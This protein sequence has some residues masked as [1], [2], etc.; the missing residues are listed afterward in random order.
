MI[1]NA[2]DRNR[3]FSYLNFFCCV[4]LRPIFTL[5]VVVMDEK[6][7][8]LEKN[9]PSSVNTLLKVLSTFESYDKIIEEKEQRIK[10]LQFRIRKIKHKNRCLQREHK[11][12]DKHIKNF[13]LTI[14]K[15]KNK[16]QCLQ[17]ENQRVQRGQFR[18]NELVRNSDP[19]V[20]AIATQIFKNLNLKSLQTCRLVCKAWNAQISQEKFFWIQEL[21]VIK[22]TW[23]EFLTKFN[24]FDSIFQLI[25]TTENTESLKQFVQKLKIAQCQWT[26]LEQPQSECFRLC[27]AFAC[28]IGH[29]EVVKCLMTAGKT[30]NINP[31]FQ[32]YDYKTGENLTPFAQACQAGHLKVVKSLLIYGK[33]LKLDFITCSPFVLAC[34]SGSVETI[35]FL[36]NHPI[37]DISM[38]DYFRALQEVRGNERL[39]RLLLN[40]LKFSVHR[41]KSFPLLL[42]SYEK[43]AAKLIKQFDSQNHEKENLVK[44]IILEE[45]PTNEDIEIH[46]TYSPDD[47]AHNFTVKFEDMKP[48]VKLER[49]ED[50]DKLWQNLNLNELEKPNRRRKKLKTEREELHCCIEVD[51]KKVDYFASDMNPDM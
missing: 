23:K 8:S 46:E 10:N 26:K 32:E 1:S 45:R 25:E 13:Q 24:Y 17:L 14:R 34:Q 15:L 44:K 29:A 37:F 16:N 28:K 43:G 21:Q 41:R 5:R 50:K 33:H 30:S 39:M 3:L 6:L 49:L 47:L 40:Y 22:K 9:N 12:K 4:K 18:I 19:K 36:L 27:L 42:K 20:N 51:F 38:D 7:H 35:Q 11:E 48:I 2:V 31:N